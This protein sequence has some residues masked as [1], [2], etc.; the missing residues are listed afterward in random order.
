MSRIKGAIDKK[1]RKKRTHYQGKPIKKKRRS[2][3]FV[4]YVSTRKRD[5]P[6]KLWFWAIRPMRRDSYLNGFSKQTRRYMRKKTYT[7]IIRIDVDPYQISNKELVGQLCIEHLWAGHWL[8]KMFSHAKNKF[9]C[10]SRGYAEIIIT[11]TPSGLRAKVIPSFGS[12]G[13]YR[14]WFWSDK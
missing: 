7:P 13:L 11:D 5:D 10:T 6:I 4:R 9:K 2:G 3:D 12:R 14:Y 1:P 8:L